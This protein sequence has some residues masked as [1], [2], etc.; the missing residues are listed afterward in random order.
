MNPNLQDTLKTLIA[1]I[2]RMDQRLLEFRDKANSSYKDLGT[3]LK[4]LETNWRR[5]AKEDESWNNT[6][7]PRCERAQPNSTADTDA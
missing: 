7:S 2:D 4:R 3:R 6:R 5:I 1:K